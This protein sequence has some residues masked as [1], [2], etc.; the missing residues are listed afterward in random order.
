MG[1][2]PDWVYEYLLAKI[3]E[4]GDAIAALD[5][6]VDPLAHA[7]LRRRLVELE[8]KHRGALAAFESDHV[9]LN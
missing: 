8:A 6:A 5:D 1:V 7:D 9:P 2:G 4:L 3:D